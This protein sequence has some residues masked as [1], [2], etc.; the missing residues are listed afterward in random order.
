MNTCPSP[1]LLQGLLADMLGGAEAGAVEAH[2]QTCPGCQQALEQQTGNA[3]NARA[4][5]LAASAGSGG[6]FLRRLEG[7]PPTGSNPT[8]ADG[9]QAE[10]RKR[11]GDAARPP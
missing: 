2:V 10:N 9:K 6:D 8:P 5:A 4:R 7:A 11:H 1:D 3:D